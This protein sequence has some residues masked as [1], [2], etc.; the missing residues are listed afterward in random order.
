MAA[1]LLWRRTNLKPLIKRPFIRLNLEKAGTDY[2]HVCDK[3]QL[4]DFSTRLGRC[5]DKTKDIIW[6]TFMWDRLGHEKHKT[7]KLHPRGF[8][9]HS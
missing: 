9:F 5:R 4:E 3:V 8:T 7:L 6:C 1:D 2:V